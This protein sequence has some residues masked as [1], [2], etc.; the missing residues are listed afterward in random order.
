MQK[1]LFFLTHAYLFTIALWCHTTEIASD[2]TINQQNDSNQTIVIHTLYGNFEI[3]EPVL[4][5]LFNSP[6]MNRIKY[7]R[8]YGT[9]DYVIKQKKE[10]TRYEHCVG[11]WALLKKYGASLEEQIAGLLHDVSHTVFSH[12]GDVL[13]NHQSLLSSYQDDIHKWYLKQQKIDLLLTQHNILL[14][15]IVG[16][17]NKHT[18]LEQ[19]L[20]DICADRLEYNLHAGILTNM[21]TIEDIAT[22]LQNLHYDQGYW[23]FTNKKIAKQFALVSLF[24]TENVWSSPKAHFINKWT[25]EALKTGLEIGLITLD[26]IHFSTD[27]I[28]WDKLWISDNQVIMQSLDKLINHTKIIYIC[29]DTQGQFLIKGKFRG[30]DPLV[31]ENNELKRL[32]ELD[33]EYK[34]EYNR[35]KRLITH[36]QYVTLLEI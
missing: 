13:F 15:N 6:A 1:I 9:L 24:N 25:A 17:D 32:T 34:E 10:Y 26:D 27:P 19:N 33:N 11:V 30:L 2:A 21:L 31:S 16:Q 12:V 5:N 35:V 36:G 23:F 4:I 20:P 22:I 18:M 28:I 7:V 14:D 29:T 3:I 8:Q